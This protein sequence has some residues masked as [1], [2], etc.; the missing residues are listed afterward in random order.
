MLDQ[1]VE[2]DTVIFNTV[3]NGCCFSP[4]SQTMLTL[5]QLTDLGLK[6]N[7]PTLSIVVKALSKQQSWETA[8]Q[9]IDSV[10]ADFRIWPEARLY[11]QLCQACIKGGQGPIGLKCYLSFLRA[12]CAHGIP[13]DTSTNTWLA[14][15][16]SSSGHAVKQIACKMYQTVVK[17]GGYMDPSSLDLLGEL[18]DGIQWK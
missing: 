15:L 10:P 16:C 2:A 1:G 5:K 9:F 6:P 8:L 7:A 11:A 12:A 17:S 3:L 4:Q 13:V 14:K 18:V